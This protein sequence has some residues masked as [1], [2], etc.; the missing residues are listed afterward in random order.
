MAVVVD[1]S[2]NCEKKNFEWWHCLE[3]RS[4]RRSERVV[5]VV[6]E[7][8]DGVRKVNKEGLRC[9]VY[10]R[11]NAWRV[12]AVTLVKAV[13]SQLRPSIDLLL[14]EKVT[15]SSRD[16]WTA[17]FPAV[18]GVYVLCIATRPFR[19]SLGSQ[20]SRLILPRRTLQG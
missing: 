19:R 9:S 5:V 2:V 12:M 4:G 1:R 7:L 20:E 10:S 18:W 8:L 16:S 3:W 17:V 6:V 11:M 13:L 15:F 14:A